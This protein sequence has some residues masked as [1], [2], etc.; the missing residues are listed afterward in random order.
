MAK[1]WKEN[2]AIWSH[3]L[4]ACSS[5]RHTKAATLT[6]N[7]CDQICHN[8]A[9]LAKNLKILG[10][11]VRVNLLYGKILNLFWQ[12]LC[13]WAIFYVV[14]GFKSNY[15]LAIRSHCLQFPSTMLGRLLYDGDLLGWLDGGPTSIGDSVAGTTVGVGLEKNKKECGSWVV[16]SKNPSL[17]SFIFVIIKAQI[18]VKKLLASVGFELGLSE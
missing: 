4:S 12:F 14:N 9:T 17:F 6:C 1:Y 5:A 15:K 10:E 7:Q 16:I 2:P 3:C 8:F 13:F 11:K 18:W